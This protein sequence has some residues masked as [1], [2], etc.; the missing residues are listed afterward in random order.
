MPLLL[1]KLPMFARTAANIWKPYKK[2][3]NAAV[4]NITPLI[5]PF[6]GL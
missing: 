3:L 4:S 6:D 2:S 1:W 5:S